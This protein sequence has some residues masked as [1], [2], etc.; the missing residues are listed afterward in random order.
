MSKKRDPIV[1]VL[2]Y[3]NNA[4]LTL[5]QQGLELAKAIVRNRLPRGAQAKPKPKPRPVAAAT[6]A[7]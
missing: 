4:E 3:F 7:S 5:A 2:N 6:S 1:A